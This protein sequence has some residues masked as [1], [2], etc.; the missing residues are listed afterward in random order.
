MVASRYNPLSP[1]QATAGA[2][3][4]WQNL[5][6]CAPAM[7]LAALAAREKRLVVALV[8]D[9]NQAFRL[10]DELRFFAAEDTPVL[11]FPDWET[12]PYDVFSPHSDIISQRLALLAGLPRRQRGLLIVAADTLLQPLPPTSFVAARTLVLNSGDELDPI[13]FRAQLESAGYAAVSEVRT[14]GEFAL[15]GAVLDLF[16]MGADTP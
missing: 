11:H 9:E 4:A 10:H 13:A 7:A 16:P 6:G 2:R 12:L 3:K 14:H 15:R 8:A 1:P 5:P